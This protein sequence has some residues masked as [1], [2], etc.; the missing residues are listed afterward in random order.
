VKEDCRN[1]CV[2]A[3]RF[4][5]KLENRPGLSHLDFRIGTYADI[6]EALLRNLDKT[7][8]LSQWTHRG[9]DDP[10]IAL[11][12]GAAILGDILT[13]YQERYAN[14]AYL[15]TAEWRDS[16]SNLV[17]LLGYRLSPGLGGAASFAFEVKGDQLVTIPPNFPLKAEVE[18]L[19]KPADFETSEPAIA[20]PWLSKFNLYRRLQTPQI[21]H[22]TTEFY[23]FAP[24]QFP[25]PTELKANDRLLIGVGN[26]LTNPTRLT[27]PEIVI[28]DSVRVL[29]GR[30]LYKIKGGLKWNGN[31]FELSAFKLGRSFHHFGSSGPRTITKAPA[32]TT[33]TATTGPGTVAGT[34]TTTTTSTPITEYTHS[35]FRSLTY[36]T[37][38]IASPYTTFLGTANSIKYVDPRLT[39]FEFALDGEVKDLS[40]GTRMIITLPLYQ[41]S[42][43]P[44]LDVTLVRTVNSIRSASQTYGLITGKATVVTFDQQLNITEGGDYWITDIR[45]MLFDEVLSPPLQLRG[46]LEETSLASD[47]QLYLYGTDDQVQSLKNRRLVFVKPGA[48]PFDRTV[49]EVQTLAPSNAARPLLRR[50]TLDSEVTLLDFPNEQPVVTVYGNIVD[51]TQGK[52]EKLVALGNGDSRL[53]FQIFKLPKSPL[54]Y[55][56]SD[57]VTPPEVPQLQIYVNN[58]LWKQVASFFGRKPDEEIYIVRED[59]ENTSWVQFGDGETGARLPSGVKNVTAVYRSGTGAFGAL[60]EKTKIQAGAKLDRLDKI[61]M[62]RAASG[63]A[64]PEDGDNAR[65]AAPG[66]I[67]SLDR[68]VSLEDFESEALGMAGVTK[69]AA[70]WELV[71]GIPQVTLIVLMETGREET[72]VTLAR[73]FASANSGR[74]PNR[75]PIIPILGKVQYVAVKA[76]FGYDSTHLETEVTK[77]IQKALGISSGK[78]NVADDPSGLFSLRRRSFGQKE[79]ATTIAGVIQ[80]VEGV[81]WVE[82]TDFDSLA[83]PTDPAAVS[84]PATVGLHPTVACGNANVLG[85]YQGHLQ[86]TS[87]KVILPEVRR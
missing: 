81:I 61:Q 10:G 3:L 64:Q 29:H 68:L 36:A 82:V 27:S 12:E 16:I 34:T 59:P 20:Y 83:V 43:S 55:L 63:G 47:N 44:P 40:T 4:P 18:G 56:H 58:R 42:G 5:R 71:D 65:A 13:F 23:I 87:Q 9:A 1:D 2:E 50:V 46:G 78:P 31:R 72:V 74:G 8:G 24:D 85:L 60:K 15:R 41:Y 52:T 35:F 79:Y 54:T 53:V 11:L 28:I 73:T 45:P 69:A 77:E 84:L 57:S 21:T 6:R 48:E 32:A 38:T 17:R 80:Q 86:L 30:K 37:V 51:A 14:E 22:D 26:S 49:N 62:P 66:K 67:Q 39:Q 25:T 19:S 7:A 75:F 33:V 70:T 76:T